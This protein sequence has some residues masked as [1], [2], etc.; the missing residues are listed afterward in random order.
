MKQQRRCCSP[1]GAQL[2][3]DFLAP[4]PCPAGGRALT[5]DQ[6]WT[7]PTESKNVYG[8][9]MGVLAISQA[10]LWTVSSIAFITTRSD[11]LNGLVFF[12]AFVLLIGSITFGVSMAFIPKSS[13]EPGQPGHEWWGV[14]VVGTFIIVGVHAAVLFWFTVIVVG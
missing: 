13:T 11:A 6:V 7:Q 9:H 8:Q 2:P 10:V 4:G 1:C 12:P 3:V 14:L 5:K